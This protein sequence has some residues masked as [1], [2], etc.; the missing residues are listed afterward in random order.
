MTKQVPCTACRKPLDQ[1]AITYSSAYP[2]DLTTRTGKPR[3]GTV[4]D[5]VR[6]WCSAACAKQSY[7]DAR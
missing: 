7:K 5:A 1:T 2:E 3:R 6:V 4:M